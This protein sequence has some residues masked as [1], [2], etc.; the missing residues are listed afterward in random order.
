MTSHCSCHTPSFQA[1]PQHLFEMFLFINPLDTQ[2]LQ[3]EKELLQFI[4]ESSQQVYFRLI[5]F[6][7]YPLF[8][9]SLNRQANH[10]LKEANALFQ[11]IYKLCLGYKAALCQG[12]KRGRLF[13][14]TMQK[15]FNEDH[16]PFSYENMTDCAT[17][18]GLD[19]DMWE[20]DYHSG[21]AKSDFQEDIHLVKQMNITSYPSLVVYDNLNYR[22][23]V[24]LQGSFTSN[25][26][27]KLIEQM[28]PQ[29]DTLHLYCPNQ[30]TSANKEVSKIPPHHSLTS[31][32]LLRHP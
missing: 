20:E 24:K 8:H 13:L 21:K 2:C 30:K 10:S 19:V 15:V 4:Q 14:M 23:G 17:L 5:A 32:S 6:M 9:Q 1:K 28:M 27:E 26:L 16:H 25:D 7:D 22:Y 12:Q 3:L 18:C 31:T 29:S 11:S